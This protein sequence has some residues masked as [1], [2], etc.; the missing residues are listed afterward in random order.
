M[1]GRIRPRLRPRPEAGDSLQTD[2][3][4]L[5]DLDLISEGID[6][7]QQRFSTIK[8]DLD[9]LRESGSDVASDEISALETAVDDC[10]TS[11]PPPATGRLGRRLT[12]QRQLRNE[13]MKSRTEPRPGRCRVPLNGFAGPWLVSASGSN[14]SAGGGDIAMMTLFRELK[15]SRQ[16]FVRSAIA[17]LV[18]ALVS[19]PGGIAN[20]LLAGV[21][22]IYGVYSM[23]AG[24]TV[25][26]SP[27][28]RRRRSFRATT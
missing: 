18:M 19:I 5:A 2:I 12:F 13:A 27:K 4:A 20:G 7:L 10:S 17:G 9:Q 22:P 21:N 28:P 23:I 3:N 14:P 16:A 1:A 15:V 8:A 24:T 6:G 11:C 26:S 25:A